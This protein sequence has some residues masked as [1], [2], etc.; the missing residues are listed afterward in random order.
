MPLQIIPFYKTMGETPLAALERFRKERPEYLHMP[1]TYAGRLDP[2]AEG[3]LIILAGEEC[4]KKDQYTALP[5][6]Y[7]VKVLFGFETD[8]YDVLGL[9]SASEMERRD[10]V[11]GSLAQD[12][13]P[14]RSKIQQDFMCADGN[15]ISSAISEA[16]KQFTGDIEQ[17][18]PPYSSRTVSSKPLFQWAR[19]GRLSEIEIPKHK[20]HV[21]SIE[22]QKAETISAEKLHKYIKKAVGLVKGDF[23]QDE[24]LSRWDGVLSGSNK[25]YQVTTLHISCSSGTYV[26]SIAHDLGR[27]LNVPA[28]ALHIK[29]T[30]IGDFKI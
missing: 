6:E 9:V 13:G 15:N 27:A 3:L 17:L 25:E 28:L 23:R 2:L 4:M 10:V 18:Y 1:L 20:V 12:D 19:E 16:L 24:I 26:R 22:L 30:K 29:R 7:E 11:P 5:K 21:E 14:S 8:T